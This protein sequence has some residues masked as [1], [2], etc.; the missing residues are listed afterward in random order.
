MRHFTVLNYPKEGENY[1][2]YA[3]KSPKRAASKAFSQ[4][5]R[6]IGLN[7]NSEKN[8]MVFSIQE[9]TRNTK[10]KTYTY[11]GT[12]VK[13][14]KPLIIKRGNKEIKYYYKN[15]ISKYQPD[16]IQTHQNE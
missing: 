1:G 13:L 11:M 14:N 3:A 10:N 7:N 8:F 4:I 12:R 2:W 6:K 16:L 5:S 15:V 9:R